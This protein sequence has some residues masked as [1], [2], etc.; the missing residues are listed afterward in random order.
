M[1]NPFKTRQTT[2]IKENK[3]SN[4]VTNPSKTRQ[5]AVKELENL[6]NDEDP[7]ARFEGDAEE[8]RTK[9]D[10]ASRTKTLDPNQGG[11]AEKTPKSV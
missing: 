4:R 8:S 11:R 1:A 9:N 10:A 6:Q 2:A 3:V 7:T 5:T